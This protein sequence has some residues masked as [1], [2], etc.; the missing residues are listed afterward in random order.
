MLDQPDS[1]N[2]VLEHLELL[3]SQI[4]CSTEEVRRERIR[5][6]VENVESMRGKGRPEWKVIKYC[7]IKHWWNALHFPMVHHTP[8]TEWQDQVNELSVCIHNSQITK[9]IS[10]F[11]FFPT[12]WIGFI[13]T[14]I[15]TALVCITA[16]DETPS[17]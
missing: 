6:Q 12:A 15:W 16:A 13:I 9:W 1:P 4:K 5:E 14:S 11:I 7:S 3:K 8:A 10:A 2:C 17:G